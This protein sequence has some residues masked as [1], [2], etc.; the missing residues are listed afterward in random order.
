MVQ[1]EFPGSIAYGTDFSMTPIQDAITNMLSMQA[2][3]M[4]PMVQAELRKMALNK[5]MPN[6]SAA[7]KKILDSEIDKMGQVAPMPV[8]A[9]TPPPP[10]PSL[11]GA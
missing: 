5:A 4:P 10:D 6:I 3:G 1:D 2:A 8:P 7:L 9:V 11:L